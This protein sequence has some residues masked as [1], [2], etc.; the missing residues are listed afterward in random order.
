MMVE[1]S[2]APSWQVIFS[3]THLGHTVMLQASPARSATHL[4]LRE[5]QALFPHT[6]CYQQT[7]LLDACITYPHVFTPPAGLEPAIFGLEVRSLVH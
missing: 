1:I 6:T 7:I 3:G 5:G 2:R 4:F